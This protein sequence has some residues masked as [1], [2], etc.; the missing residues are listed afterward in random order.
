MNNE[1]NEINTKKNLRK[2]KNSACELINVGFDPFVGIWNFT[3]SQYVLLYYSRRTS[4]SYSYYY[5]YINIFLSNSIVTLKEK[6]DEYIYEYIK[7]YW[8]EFLTYGEKGVYPN[9]TK[10]NYLD[11]Y[12]VEPQWNSKEDV[13][14]Y[15]GIKDFDLETISPYSLQ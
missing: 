13:K 4:L 9:E 3:V 2:F 12:I 5:R 6:T 8:Y 10:I 11:K 14:I 15:L 7:K 1:N